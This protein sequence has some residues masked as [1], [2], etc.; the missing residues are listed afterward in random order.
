LPPRYPSAGKRRRSHDNNLILD[1][2]ILDQRLRL[3]LRRGR[4]STDDSELS[5]MRA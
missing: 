3:D 1:N 2:L 4:E 5:A